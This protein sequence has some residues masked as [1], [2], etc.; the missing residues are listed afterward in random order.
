MPTAEKEND[1]RQEP[2][3]SVDAEKSSELDRAQTEPAVEEL[4]RRARKLSDEGSLHDA[5]RAYGDLLAIDPSHL[6]AR[7][8]LGVLYDQLGNYEAALAEYLA[9]EELDPD[10]VR[11]QC[12]IAAV[13]ASLGRYRDA[14][15]RLGQA[16]HADPQNADARENLGLVYFKK[17]LYAEAAVELRR[18]TELDPSRANAYHYLG[19]ALNHLDEIEAAMEALE[20][21]AEL[22][23]SPRTFY[24]MGILCDRKK[25]PDM[26][27]VMYRK[28]KELGRW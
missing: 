6:R 3:N 18:A 10:D 7:N 14:E 21:S 4:Y 11:L 12:N 17:G 26:A 27:E 8:N 22:R 1:P 5:A 19:E 2:M 13:Q 25:Q 9:A 16:L 15:E 28:A 24:T 20:R 23:P